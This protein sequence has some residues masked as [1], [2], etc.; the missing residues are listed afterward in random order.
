MNNLYGKPNIAPITQNR[1]LVKVVDGQS[2]QPQWKGNNPCRFSIQL[3]DCQDHM[4][5]VESYQKNRL[6]ICVM[7]HYHIDHAC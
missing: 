1:Y 2:R 7:D 3:S 5:C 6:P 4:H